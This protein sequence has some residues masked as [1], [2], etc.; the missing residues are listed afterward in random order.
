MTAIE[1]D[2]PISEFV[3]VDPHL[4]RPN[5]KYIA[6]GDYSK[7][8]RILGWKPETSFEGMLKKIIDFKVE[9]LI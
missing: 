1:D 6:C 8:Q 3:R 2:T 5:E 4:F 7:A 9:K